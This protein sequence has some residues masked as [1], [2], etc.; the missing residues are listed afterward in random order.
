[1]MR[2]FQ[3]RTPPNPN[4]N[5]IPPAIPLANF[6]NFKSV[7]PLEFRGTTELI[8]AQTWVKEIEKAFDIARVSDK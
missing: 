4:A 2:V 8:E 1:M 6:K 7:G 5:I 3:N